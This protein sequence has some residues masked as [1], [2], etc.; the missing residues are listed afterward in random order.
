MGE[1]WENLK[2]AVMRRMKGSR[3]EKATVFLRTQIKIPRRARRRAIATSASDS[4][5]QAFK[6]D[7]V[8]FP[9]L[10]PDFLLPVSIVKFHYYQLERD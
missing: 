8:V 5:G 1:V 3:W 2:G 6:F 7:L 9:M 4:P 10:V